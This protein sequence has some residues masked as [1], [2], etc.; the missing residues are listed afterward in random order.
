M[1][2]DEILKQINEILEDVLYDID[3]GGFG[4]HTAK[5]S[6]MTEWK[7][8]IS[9]RITELFDDKPSVSK[10]CDAPITEEGRCSNCKESV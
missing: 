10:C 2:K 7:K 8:E 6:E 3:C 5:C 1:K 4:N 9:K